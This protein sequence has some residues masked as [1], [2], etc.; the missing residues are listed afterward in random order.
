M[1]ATEYKTSE[2]ELS[3]KLG[4]TREAVREMR[5][6]HLAQGDDWMKLGREIHYSDAGVKK[7][8][9]TIKKNAPD[10]AN[11][12]DL[13]LPKIKAEPPMGVYLADLPDGPVLD[14]IVVR[15]YEKNP[16]Y[17]EAK[18]GSRDIQVRVR[19]N[20]NFVAG[21]VIESRQLVMAN[22]RVFDYIGR[23]PRVRGRW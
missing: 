7:L 20:Q 17:L 8:I 19:N 10:G 22:E 21:M 12:C 11:Y 18:L 9:K 5:I 23:C 16:H 4:L 3:K 6:M 2:A 13:T 14:A 1:R 15:I